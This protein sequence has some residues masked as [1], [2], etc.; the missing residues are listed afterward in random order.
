MRSS[1]KSA[2]AKK[3]TAPTRA[4]TARPPAVIAAFRPAAPVPDELDAAAFALTFL[5]PETE[6]APE[7]AAPEA[8]EAPLLAGEV[9][10]DEAAEVVPDLL[11]YEAMLV[12]S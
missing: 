1:L 11:A 8:A 5:A 4:A 7:A 6:L 2:Y 10:P 9:A 3:A 12:Y